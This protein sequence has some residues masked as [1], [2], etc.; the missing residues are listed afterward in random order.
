MKEAGISDY[1]IWLD[2]ESNTLFASLKRRDDHR[3]ADLPSSPVMRRWWDYMRDLMACHP[4]G[5]PIAVP[6]ADVFHLD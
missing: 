2:D 1:S 3:M 4:D 6:L 5:E